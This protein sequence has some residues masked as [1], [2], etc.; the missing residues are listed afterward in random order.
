MK[1][2]K[3][4]IMTIITAMMAITST[5]AFAQKQKFSKAAETKATIAAIDTIVRKYLVTHKNVVNAFVEDLWEK[6]KKNPELAVGIAKAYYHYYKLPNNPYWNY[7][8]LDTLNAYRYIKRAIEADPKYMPAYIRGGEMQIVDNEPERNDTAKA[9]QWYNRGIKANPTSPDCYIEYA[10][11][12][13]EH[14]DTIGALNKLK[15]IN[16]VVPS[17]P[18]NLAM[19]R[20]CKEVFENWTKNDIPF[21]GGSARWFD[22]QRKLYAQ[23]DIQQLDS[24]DYFDYAFSLFTNAE[25]DKAYEIAKNG[26]A[27]YPNNINILK[28]ALYSSSQGKKYD[29]AIA[30]ANKLF[31]ISDTIRFHSLDYTN[32]ATAYQNKHNLKKA[33]EMYHKAYDIWDENLRNNVPGTKFGEGNRYMS[34]I[35]NMYADDGLYE[36]A[37]A[38]NKLWIEMAKKS[39]RVSVT[40]YNSLAKLYQ[41]FALESFGEEKTKLFQAADSA[42]EQVAIVSEE[43][44]MYAYYQ[45]WKLAASELDSVMGNNNAYKFAISI[46]QKYDG[47]DEVDKMDAGNMAIYQQMCDYLRSYFIQTG[48]QGGNY[49]ASAIEKC[50]A[51]CRKILDVNPNDAKSIKLLGIFNKMKNLRRC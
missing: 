43:N 9:L 39:N 45:R 40:Q 35:V 20:V 28:V 10:K 44:Y 50:K 31:S 7:Y 46:E 13:L 38:E 21:D 48:E 27:L 2:S 8:T 49:C 12:L 18:A 15:E 16:S 26:M 51:Y 23:T 11:T 42:F 4:L 33:A 25:Y 1:V 47:L 32:A 6:D 19:A 41:D 36:D 34:T 5:T 29:E 37:I 17:Y 22:F 24:V 14:K 30:L 3:T